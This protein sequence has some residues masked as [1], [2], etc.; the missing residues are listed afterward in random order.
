M[1]APRKGTCVTLPTNTSR[2]A[3]MHAPVQHPSYQTIVHTQRILRPP[4]LP[5]LL[6]CI[7]SRTAHSWLRARAEGPADPR[8]KYRTAWPTVQGAMGQGSMTP[9]MPP[10]PL[11]SQKWQ[12]MAADTLGLSH[13]CRNHFDC[14]VS[15]NVCVYV[16]VC[17][18]VFECARAR[19]CVCSCLSRLVCAC[20]CVWQSR[21]QGIGSVVRNGLMSFSLTVHCML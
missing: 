14:L 13:G 3:T 15:I 7:P 17:V 18:C 16:C 1:P 9:N 20:V 8:S 11:S 12:S 19:S 4:P 6:H 5:K 21:A 10:G 2:T